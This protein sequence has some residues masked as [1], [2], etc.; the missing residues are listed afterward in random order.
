MWRGSEAEHWASVRIRERETHMHRRSLVI[1]AATLSLAIGALGGPAAAQEP[2]R[3]A[4]VNGIP[5]RTVDVCVGNNEVKSKLK[6][7]AWVQRTFNPGIRTVRFRNAAPGRCTGRILGTE[8]VTLIIDTDLTLVATKLPDKVIE[9]DNMT[10]PSAINTLGWMSIR[11][12]ADVGQV[13]FARETDVI[14]SA[15]PVVFVKGQEVRFV[16]I[17]NQS[18]WLTATRIDKAL[19]LAQG[20]FQVVEGRRLEIIL[21]GTNASNA[22][23]VVIYRTPVPF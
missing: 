4:F 6:Y 16:G 14:V 21:V 23:F 11:H 2:P 3:I 15:L 13:V 20:H 22:R 10:P 8:Q 12:A 17:S 18:F 9:W 19:P 1:A 7:G 5:G